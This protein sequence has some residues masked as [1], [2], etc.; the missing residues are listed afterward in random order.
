MGINVG[1]KFRIELNQNLSTIVVV[2]RIYLL[3]I[4]KKLS[5]SG[6]KIEIKGKEKLDIYCLHYI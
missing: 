3:N 6:E 2:E 5:F 1:S 4:T